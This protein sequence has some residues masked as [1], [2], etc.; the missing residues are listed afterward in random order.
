MLNW[1]FKIPGV[2]FKA[3]LPTSLTVSDSYVTTLPHAE[4]SFCTFYDYCSIA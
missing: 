4:D 3:R 1:K 2:P